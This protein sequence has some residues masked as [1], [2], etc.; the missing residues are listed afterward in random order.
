MSNAIINLVYTKVVGSAALK[1]VLIFLADVAR[2]DGTGIWCSKATIAAQ[3]ETSRSTV[4]RAIHDLQVT[5]ILRQDGTRPCANGV[6]VVYAIDLAAV[7]ALPP[8]RRPKSPVSE[9]DPYQPDTSAAVTPVAERHAK[10][11]QGDTQP[12]INPPSKEE[13]S[14]TTTTSSHPPRGSVVV[15]ADHRQVDP[16]DE[17]LLAAGID[18]TKDISGKWYSTTAL[19]SVRQWR[20][21]LGLSQA[22]ILAE[23]ASVM[24]CRDGP[25]GALSYFN[26]PM[27]RAAGRKSAAPLTPL[28]AHSRGKPDGSRL[29]D[30]LDALKARLAVQRLE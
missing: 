18:P 29:D 14:L 10:T 23:I 5:G 1:A 9:P 3:T 17:I 11:C 28:A 12:L 22:E 4:I 25:P 21:S 24:R 26:D 20:E 2:D 16:H 8:V 7:R 19:H 30:H 6:T 13:G 27:R 15:L